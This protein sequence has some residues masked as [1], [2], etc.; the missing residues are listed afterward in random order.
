[1]SYEIYIFGSMTRGEVSSSSDADVL[2]IQECSEPQLFPPSW[3]VYSQKTIKAYFAAGRLFAW[4]LHL[5]AVQVYPRL[6]SGFLADLGKPA[7]YSSLAEDLADLRLLLESSMRELEND[8]PSP[9]YELGLAYTA[10]RDIAMAASWSML[11]KPSFSRYAPYELPMRCTLPLAVYETAMRARHASTRGTEEP[12]DFDLA[13]SHLRA[14]PILE[15]AESVRS[16]ACLT[17]F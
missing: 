4:H 10:I 8:S 15:W 13:V 12:K 3:S 17:H 16:E 7:P 6:G 14:T 5:E 1:M 9:I 2:V 11:A